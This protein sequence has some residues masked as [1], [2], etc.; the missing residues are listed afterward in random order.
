VDFRTWIAPQF[1]AVVGEWSAISWIIVGGE[2]GPQARPFDIAWARTTVA[3]CKAAGVPVFVKQL[4]GAISVRNDSM[5]E[6]P[7]EDA[8]SDAVPDDYIPAYQG[9]H[10]TMRLKNRAGAE[11]AEWPEDI[12][13]REYP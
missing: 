9:E 12:R 8:F 2:S 3:Q 11:P 1:M 13:V 10:V 6:W 7:D 4:G 5:E